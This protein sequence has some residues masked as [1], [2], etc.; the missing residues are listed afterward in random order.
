MD[1]AGGRGPSSS[2]PRRLSRGVAVDVDRREVW[3]SRRSVSSDLYSL[4]TWGTYTW[5]AGVSLGLP[6]RPEMTCPRLHLHRSPPSLWLCGTS[7]VP[8]SSP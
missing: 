6:L 4:F 7:T 1:L 8:D 2:F 3:T 5:W